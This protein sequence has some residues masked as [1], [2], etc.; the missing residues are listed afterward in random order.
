MIC[1]ACGSENREGA[2]FCSECGAAFAATAPAR[3]ERKVVT[4]LFCDLV[5]ST[6]RAE[7]ADPEDV[8]AMLSVYHER[9][10]SELERFGGTVEKFIGDA[11]MALFGAPVAHEDDP[12]RAV[13]A[14]LAIRDWTADEQG[15]Q[16]RIGITTGEALVAIDA[17]PDAG[18]GMASGDVVNTAARL[19]T[20]APVNGIVVDETT[21]RASERAIVYGEQQPVAAKGKAAPVPVWQA[22]EARARL[23]VDLGREGR[24]ALV[25]RSAELELLVQTLERVRRDREP[26]L[27]TLVGVPGIGKSRLVHEL[28]RRVDAEADL[29]TWRQGRS[30]PYGE[31]LSFWAL[32]EMVKA[33]A[34]I[35]ETDTADQAVEKLRG[36]LAELGVQ[37]PEWFEVHLGPLVGAGTPLATSTDVRV[38]SF[39]AWREYLEALADFRPLVLVFE[40][41]HWASDALLDFVD[42][43]VEWIGGAPLL[44]LATARPELLTR[45]PAW[46]GGKPNAS[47]LTLAPLTRDETSRLVHALLDRAVLP[48]DVQKTLLERAEGNPLYAEEFVQLVED[49]REPGELPEGLQGLIAARLDALPATEKALLQDAAV[50]GKVFWAGA[51]AH[52]AASDAAT[53]AQALHGPVR[54]QL[55]RRERRSSIGGETEYA[56]QHGLVRDVAYAQIPRAARSEKHRRAAEW[57]E[58]LERGGDKVE[59]LGHHYLAALE[60]AQASGLGTDELALRALPALRGAGERALALG[61]SAAAQVFYERALELTRE[62][63]EHYPYLL[64][65]AGKAHSDAELA[66]DELLHEAAE[67]LLAA[68][69]PAAAAEALVRVAQVEWQRGNRDDA[70]RHLERAI[71]L[72]EDLQAS[73]EKARVLSTAARRLT[74]AEDE[75]ALPVGRLALALGEEL[76]LDDVRAESSITVGLQRW[77]NGDRKGAEGDMCR[78]IAIAE[79]AQDAVHASRGYNNLG[80]V[81]S[82][83]GDPRGRALSEKALAVTERFG[84]RAAA[85]FLRA[86]IAAFDLAAGQWDDALTTVEELIRE[87]EAGEPQYQEPSLRVLRALVR[88]SRGDLTGALDDAGRAAERARA[89]RDPQLLYPTLAQAAWVELEAG[90][91][92]VART[93]TEDVS[94]K[95]LSLSAS[96]TFF[97]PLLERLGVGD[98]FLEFARDIARPHAWIEA[99]EAYLRGDFLGAADAYAP[100]SAVDEAY[101]RLRAAGELAA[102]GRRAEADEQLRRSLGFWR[103]VGATRYVAEGESLLAASA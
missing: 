66:G 32:G 95:R 20:A 86:N 27:V 38:E 57:I 75:R 35:L 41:L 44:V 49:G 4:V 14:A 7:G 17:R 6:A 68:G 81:L 8:R 58:S 100:I 51:V 48:A 52:L 47:A 70:T 13:R 60:L 10:R 56:F 29:I 92:S 50:I 74:L 11:V 64:L 34:G 5:G 88:L 85:R 36:S 2:K 40:D 43:L 83:I 67:R 18:E 19:Q 71:G 73:E 84:Q 65:G 16:V 59:L 53:V 30:L 89:I 1:P 55:A 21:R 101:A 80:S 37:N 62:S 24:A 99:A 103:S 69:D 63:D 12:E 33:Q 97:A 82:E 61:A 28:L 94:T 76:G 102:E 25:G 79:A 26:Q 3:E 42:E 31:G 87:T 22:V 91:E 54:R 77:H 98:E 93:L 15:V 9:V 39:T 96:S 78:G 23:G 72:V 46:G 45:R 90:N